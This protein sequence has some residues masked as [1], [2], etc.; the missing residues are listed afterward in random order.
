MRRVDGNPRQR[1][2]QEW[3]SDGS[4][5]KRA[6]YPVFYV[7][8]IGTRVGGWAGVRIGRGWRRWQTAIEGNREIAT[9]LLKSRPGGSTGL[10]LEPIAVQAPP[11][12]QRHH[13]AAART[14]ASF[15]AG[16]RPWSAIENRSSLYSRSQLGS[17]AAAAS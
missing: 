4:R 7:V 5:P 12:S 15:S 10:G 8:K 11:R 9:P 14:A 17:A 16:V 3:G 1:R 2:E 6:P 13:A